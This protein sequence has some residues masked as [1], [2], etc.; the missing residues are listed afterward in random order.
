MR[1]CDY[2]LFYRR[3]ELQS[4]SRW[5]SIVFCSYEKNILQKIITFM[6]PALCLCF[7]ISLFRHF[8]VAGRTTMSRKQR[9]LS[10]QFGL[11]SRPGMTPK[12]AT[13]LAPLQCKCLSI[14]CSQLARSLFPCCQKVR[15]LSSG[16]CVRVMLMF[17]C[18]LPLSTNREHFWLEC[19]I[20]MATREYKICRNSGP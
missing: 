17:C 4:K 14:I 13:R 7:L 16:N 5:N 12:I 3:T 10:R 2:F 6:A 9:K 15:P 1:A 20:E 18:R 8:A 11:A 19:W